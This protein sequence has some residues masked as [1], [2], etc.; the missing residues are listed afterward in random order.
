MYIIIRV[1]L[2]QM[3]ALVLQGCAKISE[4]FLEQVRQKKQTGSLVESL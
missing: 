3:D 4:C 1:A 2:D